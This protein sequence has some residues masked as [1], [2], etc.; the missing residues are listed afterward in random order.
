M[1]DADAA[2][3]YR[4]MG[5]LADVPDQTVALLAKRLPPAEKADAERITRLISRLDSKRFASRQDA[6]RE[7]SELAEI[8]EAA[9]TKALASNPSE[10]ARR[11]LTALREKLNRGWVQKLRAVEVLEYVGTADA[12]RVLDAIARGAPDARLTREA[13]ATLARM[14]QADR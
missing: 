2:L 12:K 6:A 14:G 11:R 10:E 1:A 7:L 3:A 4:A 9:V 8:A 13:R 5:D